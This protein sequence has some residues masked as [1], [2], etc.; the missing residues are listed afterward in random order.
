[1]STD[2]IAKAFSGPM[3]DSLDDKI[4]DMCKYVV[5]VSG[6]SNADAPAF[7]GCTIYYTLER[8]KC[9]RN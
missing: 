9:D 8:A 7:I 4:L 6:C 5:Q 3:V 2:E 1:M